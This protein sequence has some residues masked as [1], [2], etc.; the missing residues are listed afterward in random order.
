MLI[1]GWATKNIS[2]NVTNLDC[3][4]CGDQGLILVAFQ[5]F[6]DLFFIPTIPLDKTTVLIC[7]NCSTEF[8]VDPEDV[9]E[10][11]LPKVK[12]PI[13][14]FAG[15][16]VIAVIIGFGVI[17]GRLDDNK[18]NDFIQNP[19][20]NDSF[21]IKIMDEKKTPFGHLNIEAIDGDKIIYRPSVYIYSKEST[22]KKEAFGPADKKD[23]EDELY[24]MTMSEFH[25]LNI[26]S[27]KRGS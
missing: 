8:K 3:S 27:F 2:E 18:L 6:F 26:R 13:W 15:L 1:W 17:A 4:H 12:T 11:N 9:K 14:G 23:M 10:G 25:D 19:R 21:V 24:E 16:I 5:R 20:V 7:K 22:A